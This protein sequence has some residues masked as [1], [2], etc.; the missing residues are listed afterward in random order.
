MGRAPGRLRVLRAVFGTEAV[1]LGLP[2]SGDAA[3]ARFV[4]ALGLKMHVFLCLVFLEGKTNATRDSPCL[5]EALS[6]AGAWK[7][8][9]GG[10]RYRDRRS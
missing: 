2:L 1:S 9:P 7:L 5:G 4:G 10:R 8:D 3:L 6:P